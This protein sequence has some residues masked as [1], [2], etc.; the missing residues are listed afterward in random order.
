[1]TEIWSRVADGLAAIRSRVLISC[2]AL[3]LLTV[4]LG[5]YS[6]IAQRQLADLAIR[7]YDDAFMSVSYL[8]AAQLGFTDLAHQAP[9]DGSSI[10]AVTEDLDV[11]GARAMS[12]AGR[13]SV[14]RL[15]E[16]VSAATPTDFAAIQNEF[17]SVVEIF[18]DDGFRYRRD[19]TRMVAD[20]VRRTWAVIAGSLLAALI[21]TGLVTRMIAPPV[22]RAAHIAQAIA[23]GRLDNI[24]PQ[25]GRPEAIA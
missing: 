15:R 11:A 18:A 14:A 8:R 5:A 10:S 13:Q 9:D 23:S 6:Q 3:T 21:I 16:H 1:M 19:I 24:I 7:I 25:S 20:E 2:L 12:D 22:R 17:E 4:I